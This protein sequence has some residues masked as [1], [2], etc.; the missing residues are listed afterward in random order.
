MYNK[1]L[2]LKLFKYL[3]IIIKLMNYLF[4]NNFADVFD[5]LFVWRRPFN[6][7]CLQTSEAQSIQGCIANFSIHHSTRVCNYVPRS[8]LSTFSAILIIHW[9][10][11]IEID[12]LLV[13]KY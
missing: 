4:Q 1:L 9:L 12:F 11:I 13:I 10:I 5:I 2:L 7:L 6:I 3:I 8:E